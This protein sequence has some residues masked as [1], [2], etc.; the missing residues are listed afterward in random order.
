VSDYERIFLPNGSSVIYVDDD[1]SYWRFNEATGKRGRRLTGVTTACKSLDIDPTNLLKW[2]ART[3]LLGAATLIDQLGDQAVDLM[4]DPDLCWKELER[5]QLTYD[6]V[7]D[8]AASEGT[9]VHV[10][11]MEALAAGKPA[12]DTSGMGDAERGKAEAVQA[13]WHDHAPDVHLVEQVVYSERL[14]VAGRLDLLAGLGMTCEDPGCACHDEDVVGEGVIDLKTGGF[15]SAAA[16]TQV[17]GGYPLLL[18]ESG[19]GEV[20]WGLILQVFDDGTYRLMR[21]QGTPEGFEIAVRNYREAGR[22]VR[23][24]QKARQVAEH[25]REE[26]VPA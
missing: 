16:H 9:R 17:G 6:D 4:R 15:I 21:A 19:F 25:A 2:A 8:R 3:Q 22:I 14:G 12:P 26:V 7:R 5:R 23:A 13:F 10:Q 11:A 20:S 24:S 18:A 1:H